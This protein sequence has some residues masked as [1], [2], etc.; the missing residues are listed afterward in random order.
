MQ[1]YFPLDLSLAN[2]MVTLIDLEIHLMLHDTPYHE[3]C[4]DSLNHTR[5]T[6][7]K[8]EIVVTLKPYVL[9]QGARSP[10]YSRCDE[11]VTSF[12][13]TCERLEDVS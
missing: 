13:E 9:S 3:C 8:L 12:H 6:L 1:T 4:F 2:E 5:W 11:E 10:P 7:K